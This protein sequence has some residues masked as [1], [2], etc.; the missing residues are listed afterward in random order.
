MSCTGDGSQDHGLR[1]VLEPA[2]EPVPG[3]GTG[4]G[5]AEA[6]TARTAVLAKIRTGSKVTAAE[7]ISAFLKARARRFKAWAQLRAAKSGRKRGLGS[8][9]GTRLRK[10][11]HGQPGSIASHWAH[12]KAAA[13]FPAE[14]EGSW[15]KYV[16][17]AW[18]A[19][20][21]TWCG[22]LKVLGNTIG[23]AGDHARTAF[24]LLVIVIVL[25]VL[26]A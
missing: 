26:F 16:R 2:P 12:V 24:V 20:G 23:S 22:F 15:L 4:P 8:M 9:V 19:F 3:S 11:H 7:R 18:K 13:W 25:I 14:L 21:F 1:L 5:P 17:F 6:G 10:M